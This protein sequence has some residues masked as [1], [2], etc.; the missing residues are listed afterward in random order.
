MNS[1]FTVKPHCAFIFGDSE[2][3]QSAGT[4]LFCVI[5]VNFIKLCILFCAVAKA[6]ADCANAGAN[7]QVPREARLL[8]ATVFHSGP[9]D[10]ISGLVRVHV[11][12]RR[13]LAH[14]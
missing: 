8:S 1:Q 12:P 3:Y 13:S 7:T 5:S 10:H 6:N 4:S 2:D 9:T 14:I 11:W